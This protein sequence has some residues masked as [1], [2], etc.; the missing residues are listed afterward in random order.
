VSNSDY[1]PFEFN[2]PLYTDYDPGDTSSLAASSD[3]RITYPPRTTSPATLLAQTWQEQ[4]WP[5]P[6]LAAAAA[7]APSGARLI[8]HLYPVRAATPIVPRSPP[9]ATNPVFDYVLRRTPS[10]LEDSRDYWPDL[11]YPEASPPSNTLR[12]AI[13]DDNLDGPRPSPLLT[14]ANIAQLQSLSN[15]SDTILVATPQQPE[16]TPS[17]PTSG[18]SSPSYHIHTPDSLPVVPSLRTPSIPST[19]SSFSYIP[20]LS[21]EETEPD[22]DQENRPPTPLAE[23]TPDLFAPPACTLVSHTYH[24]HQYYIVPQPHGDSWEAASEA[25]HLRLLNYPYFSDLVI[26]PPALPTV[27]PYKAQAPHYIRIQPTDILRLTAYRFPR[28]PFVVVPDIPPLT[29]NLPL[30]FLVYSFR[31]SIRDTLLRLPLFARLVFSYSTVLAELHDFLDGRR[32]YTYGRLRFANGKVYLVDQTYHIEDSVLT[33]PSLLR[34]SLSPRIPSEPLAN[35]R[36]Y[37]DEDP[38]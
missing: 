21:A 2:H 10:P 32:I 35:I 15:N 24:P 13:D 16:D 7:T 38:L 5:S 6:S 33:Y 1:D 37:R 4:G 17:T 30:G 36:T 23:L 25:H 3:I 18:I 29:P 12:L 19:S 22:L 9:V 27:T 28:S 11:H 34:F 14:F 8:D 26:N 20:S 31:V